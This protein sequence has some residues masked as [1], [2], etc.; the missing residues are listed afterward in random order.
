MSQTPEDIALERI[1]KAAESGAESLD[2]YELG[3]TSLPPEVG[4]LINLKRIDLDDNQLSSLP[5][6]I[7]QLVNL[8]QLILTHNQL[9]S[10]PPELCQLSNLTK[11]ILSNNLLVSLPSEIG[12]LSSM[13]ELD[14]SNNQLNSLPPE[15]GKLSNLKLLYLDNNYLTTLPSEIVNLQNLSDIGLWGNPLEISVPINILGD[16]YSEND[17]A[18]QFLMFYKKILEGGGRSLSEARVFVV[19]ENGV[20][21]TSLINRLIYSKFDPNEEATLGLEKSTLVLGNVRAQM[22]DFGGQEYMQALHQIFF[23]RRSLYLL[24]FDLRQSS[25][26][27]RLD[28]WLTLI[29]VYSQ[30]A[31]VIMVGSK[32][33][34]HIMD[35]ETRRLRE[36]YP[37]IRS[38]IFTSAVSMTNIEEL[39]QIIQNEIQIM[40]QSQI[41]FSAGHLA[42]KD[43]IENLNKPYISYEYFIEI[44]KRYSVVEEKDQGNLLDLLHDI[45]LVL[46]FRN[47]DGNPLFPSLGLLNPNW[48]TNIIY[49][50][51]TNAELKSAYKGKLS[52]EL[53]RKM[54][55][56]VPENEFQVEDV[57]KLLEY[58]EL[59]FKADDSSYWLPNLMEKDEPANLGDFSSV[60]KFEYL[61][62]QLSNNVIAR[63]IVKT[64]NYIL[65][66]NVWRYGVVLKLDYNIA[67]IRANLQDNRITI[68]VT[69]EESTRPDLLAIIRANFE[70]IHAAFEI[71][72][73]AYIYP[74]Q[75]PDLR[76]SFEDI[77]ILSK[78]ER[79]YK[80][81]YQGKIVTIPLSN[82]I[83]S[84]VGSENPK[85][86]IDF[87]NDLLEEGESPLNEARVMVVGDADAGKTKLLHALLYKEWGEKFTDNRDPTEGIK[88]DRISIGEINV[89]FWDFGGQEI[90][91]ATHRF[92]LSEQCI[93]ILVTDANRNDSNIIEYW[94]DIIRSFGGNSPVLLVGS[95]A[96]KF[97]LSIPERELQSKYPNLVHRPVLQTS[98]KTGAG[99][100]ELRNALEEQIKSLPSI[101]NLIPRSYTLI[102]IALEEK[103]KVRSIITENEYKIIC[104]EYGVQDESRQYYLLQLLH[105]IGVIFHYED[106]RL[107]HLDVLNPDWVTTS[108]YIVVHSR[109]IQDTHGK[110]T[111][112]QLKFILSDKAGYSRELRI[113]IVDL[114]KKFNLAYELP[115]KKDT[116]ILLSALPKDQPENMGNWDNCMTFEYAYT[117]LLPSVFHRFIVAMNEWILDEKV[118]H[119]GVLLQKNENLALVRADLYSKLVTIKIKGAEHSRREFLDDIC[120]EF[121]YIHKDLHKKPTA[122]ILSL[123]HPEARLD[124]EELRALERDGEKMWRR[125]IGNNLITFNVKEELDGFVSP[126]R[127]RDMDYEYHKSGAIFNTFT[128]N[129]VTV[130]GNVQGSS[131]FAG[132]SNTSNQTVQNSFN[133]F[134]PELQISLLELMKAS[135]VLLQIVQD[136]EQKED[137]KNELEDLQKEANKSKPKKDKVKL[138]VEGLAQAAKNLNDVGKPVLELATTIIKLIN[139][140][141]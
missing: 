45:G 128:N 108:V 88:V 58:F 133:T 136:D 118:W 78:S 47:S 112:E 70:D 53:L 50:V 55:S 140:L 91:H 3:L 138:S 6:E 15:I 102:K 134:P 123:K 2:L 82:L 81:I 37:N 111:L 105:N 104:S 25:E 40:P 71:P 77:K 107:R 63:F 89:Q 62:P 18:Q 127:R 19:G 132:D 52:V 9:T 39:R 43:E 126:E 7:C 30:N 56:S 54:L 95:K 13:V 10:L 16:K 24:V 130:H 1:R 69:G 131:V 119:N 32:Y 80:T 21:K 11:L 103:K 33:D 125:K 29:K 116:Y 74:S 114:I 4:Q 5:P 22:W 84:Y 46:Y 51:V 61:Y 99:I 113:F 79:D 23:S 129:N 92:F 93:Y 31:P 106:E 8:K 94:L 65:G 68:W 117:V 59:C 17:N 75:Y 76:L 85:A 36:I 109:Q 67:L 28:Y 110:F 73:Q 38:F 66:N 42:V 27:N 141:P 124:F 35:I 122:Y 57:G 44:C 100:E 48:I 121:K 64:H 20:G 101:T 86:K 49:K 26:Q 115:M 83:D 98:A 120:K 135:E 96:E 34:Q 87:Y 90:S 72:P 137:I 97:S 41:L 14:L 139:N 12:Q 60:M